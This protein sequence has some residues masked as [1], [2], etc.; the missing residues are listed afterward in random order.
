LP[1]PNVHVVVEL[2]VDVWV[3]TEGG[4]LQAPVEDLLR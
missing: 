4:L 2:S 1:E 3:G